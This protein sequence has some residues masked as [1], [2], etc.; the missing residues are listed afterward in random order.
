ML[1]LAQTWNKQ[2]QASHPEAAFDLRGCG[3]STGFSALIH[4][5]ADLANASRAVKQKEFKEAQANNIQLKEH[6]VAYDAIAI[7]V[8]KSNPIDWVSTKFLAEI[9]G[10]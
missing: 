3:S 5:S 2:Y 7:Y 8:H 4:G 9:Y 10:Q 6:L 1:H